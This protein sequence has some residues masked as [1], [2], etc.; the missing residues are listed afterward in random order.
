MSKK[1]LLT[2]FRGSS[3]EVLI[4]DW[5]EYAIIILPNDKIKDSELLEET[6]LKGK[7]DY[8]ISFGQKPNIKDKVY[9][10]T[11]ARQRTVCIE[12]IFPWDRLTHI[13]REVGL[14]VTIS[15]NAGTSFCN[16]LYYN[17]LRFIQQSDVKAKMVFIHIPFEKNISDMEQL[18]RKIQ[19]AIG[20][21]EKT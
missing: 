17:G 20:K 21:L 7:Y 16:Q 10:E 6:M 19:V 3:A 5:D 15:D 9:V 11:T 12:T 13:F 4:E 14:F 18:R 1:V 2:A 8:I